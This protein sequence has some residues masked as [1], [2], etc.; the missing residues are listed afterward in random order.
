MTERTEA[1]EAVEFLSRSS[2]RVRLLETLRDRGRVTRDELRSE[3]SASRTTVSR[4]LEAL[5]ERGWVGTTDR[6]YALTPG[7]D[8]IVERFLDLESTVATAERLRPFLEHVDR[9]AFDVDLSLLDDATV[10]V[11]RAGDPLAMVNAHVSAIKRSTDAVAAVPFLGLHACEAVHE[12]V[13]DGDA[14]VELVASDDVVATFL[15]G[16]SY[17]ELAADLQA[18]DGFTLTRASADVPFYVGVLDDVAQVGVDDDGEPRALLETTDPAVREW[19]RATID[20]LR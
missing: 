19:A 16:P 4:N 12:T 3:L 9:E 15:E 8:A 7:T 17:A 2:T 18:A 13:V 5:C 11:P 6:E 10:T 20:S 1:V 14:R